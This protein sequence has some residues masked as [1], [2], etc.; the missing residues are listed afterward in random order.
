[1]VPST[2]FPNLA[3]TELP[4]PLCQ[5]TLNPNPE[6]WLGALPSIALNRLAATADRMQIAPDTA[7]AEL[8]ALTGRLR[9]VVDIHTAAPNVNATGFPSSGVQTLLAAWLSPV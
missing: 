9:A 3:L 7:A 5:P 1:M 6:A 2:P 8:S 4:F